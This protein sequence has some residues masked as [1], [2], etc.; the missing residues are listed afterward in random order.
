MKR[1]L[2]SGLICGGIVL[3]LVVVIGLCWFIFGRNDEKSP[4]K[5][6]A[7]T[8]VVLPE[9]EY[10][11]HCVLT[12][13]AIRYADDGK[14]YEIDT[15][16][17]DQNKV[18]TLVIDE[19]GIIPLEGR[20]YRVYVS[21]KDSRS[22][23]F[24]APV[25]S[26]GIAKTDLSRRII[27]SRSSQ[28]L[29][30]ADK[31]SKYHVAENSIFY[32]MKVMDGYLRRVEA[33]TVES[34]AQYNKSCPDQKNHAHTSKCFRYNAYVKF[35][36]GFLTDYEVVWAALS[37]D[38]SSIY[39]YLGTEED[40]QY[41]MLPGQE[42]TTAK[43]V[44][45]TSDVTTK[46]TIGVKDFT[47]KA[48]TCNVNKDGVQP[49]GGRFYRIDK[50]E[51][52]S[53]RFSVPSK[54][55]VGNE[56]DFFAMPV[57]GLDSD[58]VTFS[59][60]TT[61]KLTEKTQMLRASV[62]W[63]GW[64]TLESVDASKITLAQNTNTCKNKEVHEHTKSCYY[65]NSY[66]KT[67]GYNG[68]DWIVTEKTGKSI[69]PNVGCENDTAWG[70]CDPANTAVIL[71]VDG[72]NVKLMDMNGNE[73]TCTY[74]ASKNLPVYEGGLYHIEWENR[75]TV[76]ISKA[77]T[78]TTTPG[79]DCVRHPLCSIDGNTLVFGTGENEKVTKL[80]ADTKIFYMAA[81]DNRLIPMS[82]GELQ[83]AHHT[84]SCLTKGEHEHTNSCY[85]YNSIFGCDGQGNL[86]WVICSVKN[87]SISATLGS[88]DNKVNAYASPMKTCFT[89]TG[90]NEKGRV[91]IQRMN[92]T[93][94]SY[95]VH[96]SGL[97]PVKGRIY[98]CE[99]KDGK[100]L[101]SNPNQDDKN[102]SRS[103]I[104]EIEDGYIT[105]SD[106]QTF[107]LT[108]NTRIYSVEKVNDK[109][110]LLDEPKLGLALPT[111]YCKG[112]GEGHEHVWN[113]CY[114][115]N[116]VYATDGA[117]TLLWMIVR[118]DGNAISSYIG[119]TNTVPVQAGSA[120]QVLFTTS[121]I[122]L[123]DGTMR[124]KGIDMTGAVVEGELSADSF[125]PVKGSI[126]H[127]EKEN[128]RICLSV[129]NADYRK[130]GYDFGRC[131]LY[132]YA[133]DTLELLN[134]EKYNVTSATKIFNVETVGGI[135]VLK[136][137]KDLPIAKCKC[138]ES[139]THVND[140]Y[141]YN[142]FF[143][144]DANDDLMWIMAA[145]S[146]MSIFYKSGLDATDLV[147]SGD[148]AAVAVTQSH[149]YPV[150]VDGV[151]EY[152]VQIIDMTGTSVAVKVDE[153]G[154]I[155]AE[156]KGY[157]IVRNDDGTVRF[158][159]PTTYDAPSDSNV[160]YDFARYQALMADNSHVVLRNG[161]LLTV[162]ADT[163]VFSATINNNKIKI[164]PSSTIVTS[165]ATASCEGE[166]HNHVSGC[167][168]Y[169]IWY[170]CDKEGNLK[171]IISQE[172]G[173]KSIYSAQGSEKDVDLEAPNFENTP[174]VFVTKTPYTKDGQKVVDLKDIFGKTYT[175]Q[176]LTNQSASD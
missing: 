98:A 21:K 70:T 63:T 123:K 57:T 86:K 48:Y 119:G 40:T 42:S 90:V 166:E 121:S 2:R 39:Y 135:L 53:V 55:R 175:A 49:V 89:L 43:L 54:T 156:G 142:M 97:A 171:W 109:L 163:K 76:K 11:I 46:G 96:P 125:F 71:L 85:Y 6:T 104:V 130:A 111:T 170:A 141:T 150:W 136:E 144:V 158:S 52:G 162:T 167:F 157:H 102:F 8:T 105:I 110:V 153:N 154:V 30:T 147:D 41:A 33:D 77:N 107:R 84:N 3:V 51:D 139:H 17:L 34:F 66:Y 159:Q 114:S 143:A 101:F 122:I 15:F 120:E 13:S 124:I 165:K 5:K 140:C 103:G 16:S 115:G 14:S 10:N 118:P 44:V 25:N 74:T 176:P 108:E 60:T 24:A 126:Y 137:G 148:P 145:P 9:S 20:V 169:T 78:T 129:P 132:K 61:K 91:E 81:G 58:N 113:K 127:M 28:W 67:D 116:F 88:K 161:K 82:S 27:S 50:Q 128:G 134:G 19:S 12:E 69:Y 31:S 7:N 168:P 83:T 72:K 37:I 35:N 65:Y 38:G 36:G 56:Y 106:H 29:Y 18:M 26:G 99:W 100:M 112:L 174:V 75:E 94:T 32:Y 160:G 138:T 64:M 133:D 47:G 151:K 80:T 87:S 23:V 22:A 164:T 155:P 173:S 152:R 95:P 131:P 59:V 172:D 73:H 79:F 92:G 1:K 62:S 93:R 149:T 68:V 117:G 146:D 4:T 45:T